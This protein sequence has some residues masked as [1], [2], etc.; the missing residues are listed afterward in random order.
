MHAVAEQSRA[1][2]VRDSTR[3]DQPRAAV[4]CATLTNVS[5]VARTSNRSCA[6]SCWR[7]PRSSICKIQNVRRV[8]LADYSDATLRLTPERHRRHRHDQNLLSSARQL[9]HSE[10]AASRVVLC[11]TTPSRRVRQAASVRAPARSPITQVHAP[12]DDEFRR[13]L[14]SPDHGTIQ[15]I[16]IFILNSIHSDPERA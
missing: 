4:P 12:A 16:L 8:V 10:P 14:V 3:L 11:R 2:R 1:S 6:E 13:L 7:R 9:C 15:A 5:A